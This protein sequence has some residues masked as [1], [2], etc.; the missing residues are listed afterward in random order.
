M[1]NSVQ[2]DPRYMSTPRGPPIG[3]FESLVEGGMSEAE[4]GYLQKIL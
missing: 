3:V 2:S 4:A 1:K